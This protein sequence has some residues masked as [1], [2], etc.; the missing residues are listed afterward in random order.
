[1]SNNYRHWNY[2]R[3]LTIILW[4]GSNLTRKKEEVAGVKGS[5]EQFNV[6]L[7]TS[8]SENH[9]QNY[10]KKTCHTLLL[11]SLKKKPIKQDVKVDRPK[12]NVPY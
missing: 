11:S 4:I 1:M 2:T 3:E 10:E 9:M 8:A 6:H 5:R 7:Y 12:H